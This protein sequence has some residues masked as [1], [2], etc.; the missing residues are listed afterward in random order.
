MSRC[1]WVLDRL[2]DTVVGALDSDVA[3]HLEECSD[4]REL[5]E[6]ATAARSN[7]GLFAGIKA[8]AALVDRLKR[9]PR[10]AAG[11]E[12]AQKLI[13]LALD[14]EI[15]AGERSELLGHMHECP[16]CRS[17]WDAFATLREVGAATRVPE[18][19]RAALAIHPRNNLTLRR[20]RKFFD[21]RLATAAAYL[22]AALSVAAAGNPG[23]IARAGTEQMEKATFYAKAAV[24]NRIDSYADKAKHSALQVAGWFGDA[25]DDARTL[26][27]RMFGKD[28]NPA[29]SADVVPDENGGTR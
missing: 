24:E 17:T 10:L 16:A 2:E 9:L 1:T 11:C 20:K 13:V 28:A 29:A 25:F 3:V 8:P 7:G 18:R 6:A 15:S 19:F 4:C 5:V 21:L 12:R 26:A 22:L 27:R 14:D 23:D